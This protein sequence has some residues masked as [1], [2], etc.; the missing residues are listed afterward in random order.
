MKK[1]QKS[2]LL[3]KQRHLNE[4]RWI[5]FRSKFDAAPLMNNFALDRKF[6]DGIK[7][8]AFRWHYISEYV[9]LFTCMCNLKRPRNCYY[10]ATI[11]LWHND[12]R[13]HQHIDNEAVSAHMHCMRAARFIVSY[14]GKCVYVLFVICFY[15]YKHGFV[16]VYIFFPI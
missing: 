6:I 14:I 12:R 5:E 11:Y 13:Q 3:Y 8:P 16:C 2:E 7:K 10:A 15:I 9:C 4:K 1:M